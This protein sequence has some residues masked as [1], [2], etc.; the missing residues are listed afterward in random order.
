MIDLG[1]IFRKRM[2]VDVVRLPHAPEALPEYK[3]AESAGM[4]LRAAI[5]E[6]MTLEP[7]QVILIP[8]GI[9][10]AIRNSNYT[11]FIFPRSGKSTKEGLVLANTLG[12]VDADYRGE[13]LIPVLN[14]NLFKK[15]TIEPGER[16][17]QMVFMPNVMA[18]LR[19]TDTLDETERGEGRFGST[20][21]R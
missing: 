1:T 3:T 19:E 21:S 16:I 12:V 14:R 4:D 5:P 7:Q 10:I 18:F 11:G 6:A 20:G 17:A 2:F 15:V 9:K 13:V 8:T